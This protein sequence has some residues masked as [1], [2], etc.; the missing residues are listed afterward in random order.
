MAHG[1]RAMPVWGGVFDTTNQLFRGAATSEE[2][3]EAVIAYLRDLQ[4]P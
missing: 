4:G 2:R 3:I 1:G